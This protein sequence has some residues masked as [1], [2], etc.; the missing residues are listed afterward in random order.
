MERMFEGFKLGTAKLV[1]RFMFPPISL[2]L[3]ERT[4][5]SMS[6]MEMITKNLT[7]MRIRQMPKVKRTVLP[8]QWVSRG[9]HGFMLN[10]ASVVDVALRDALREQSHC[11]PGALAAEDTPEPFCSKVWRQVLV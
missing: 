11:V 5:Q 3:L 4:P 6:M 1:N 2:P 10:A 8:G 9:S 7:L